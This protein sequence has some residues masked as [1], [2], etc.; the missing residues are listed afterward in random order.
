MI[1]TEEQDFTQVRF[2]KVFSQQQVKKVKKVIENR[3]RDV[4]YEVRFD[5][6]NTTAFGNF[7]LVEAF[8]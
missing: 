4:D 3:L 5:N 2:E 8:K 7:A 1:V 6:R